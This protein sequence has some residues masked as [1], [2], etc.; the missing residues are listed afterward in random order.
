[1]DATRLQNRHKSWRRVR[2]VTRASRRKPTKSYK[3]LWKVRYS[4]GI[5]ECIWSYAYARDHLLRTSTLAGFE[6]V[7]AG[8]IGG[9]LE[10]QQADHLA[11][12]TPRAHQVSRAHDQAARRRAQN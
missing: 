5:S 8:A 9:A 11:S 10:H 7:V 4:I 12:R 1:M 6:R 2:F 3:R